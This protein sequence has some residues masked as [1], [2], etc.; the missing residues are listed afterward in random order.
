MKNNIFFNYNFL[1]IFPTSYYY[2]TSR[3]SL[4]FLLRKRLS[5][6]SSKKAFNSLMSYLFMR[7]NNKTINKIKQ[8]L[9]TNH[10][11]LMAL[12]ISTSLKSYILNPKSKIATT[13]KKQLMMIMCF[14]AK[15]RWQIYS[16][17]Q[18][19]FLNSSEY[20]DII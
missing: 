3:L 18:P 8:H 9:I 19:L 17:S 2:R 13:L 12:L 6:S 7:N 14:L 5:L 16:A 10:L 11:L 4:S 1:R 20:F 15:I